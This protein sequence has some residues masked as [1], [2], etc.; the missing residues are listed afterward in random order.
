MSEALDGD[1]LR[2]IALTGQGSRQA[3]RDLLFMDQAD[4][5]MMD[6]HVREHAIR[7][8]LIPEFDLEE[9]IQYIST[10]FPQEIHIVARDDIASLA[11]L[12]GRPVNIGPETSGGFLAGTILFADLGNPNRC[13]DP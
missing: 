7:N 2:V 5:V 4:V 3:Q 9:S 10:L 8:N 1:D 12:E 11:D 6:N 13:S